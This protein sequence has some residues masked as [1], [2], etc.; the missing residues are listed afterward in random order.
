MA[1][2]DGLK[3]II[4]NQINLPLIGS[5]SVPVVIGTGLLLFLLLRKKRVT[6]VTTRYGK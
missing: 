4:G 1:I 2:T 6:S 3:S 5:V